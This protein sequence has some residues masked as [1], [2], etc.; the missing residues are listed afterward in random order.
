MPFWVNPVGS[1]GRVLGAAPCR[2][3]PAVLLNTGR[4]APSA[5]RDELGVLQQSYLVQAERDGKHAAGAGGS[6]R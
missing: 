4:L 2:R 3:A 1:L 5:Q 6:R